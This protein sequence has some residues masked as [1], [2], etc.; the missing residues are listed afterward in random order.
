MKNGANSFIECCDSVFRIS[1]RLV[2]G[3]S[4]FFWGVGIGSAES[5][6]TVALGLDYRFI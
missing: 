6:S 4:R 1:L 3:L 2:S 5:L